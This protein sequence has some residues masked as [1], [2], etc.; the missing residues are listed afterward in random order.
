MGVRII[1]GLSEGTP[2]AAIYDSVSGFAF[3]P[4]F[5]SMHQA[6]A[7]LSFVKGR[8]DQDIRQL[9]DPELE[10]AMK[11]FLVLWRKANA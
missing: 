10:K 1:S 2:M 5:E 3:G 11:E 4:T 6:V 8:H 9:A 7:Y